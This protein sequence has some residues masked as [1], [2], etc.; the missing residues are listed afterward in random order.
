MVNKG[1]INNIFELYLDQQ[2]NWWKIS[3]TNKFAGKKFYFFEQYFLLES[4]TEIRI[5]TLIN[6]IQI[7]QRFAREG[8]QAGAS[9][10]PWPFFDLKKYVNKA[11]K[12]KFVTYL[13]QELILLYWLHR[14]FHFLTD[15]QEE[16]IFSSSQGLV[17][18]LL[19]RVFLQ[20]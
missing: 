4:W 13:S 1:Q 15:R 6:E 8:I 20:S 12:S 18:L 17:A 19:C 16:S 7:H 14:V 9:P 10:I 2:Q 5:S 11:K 3:N